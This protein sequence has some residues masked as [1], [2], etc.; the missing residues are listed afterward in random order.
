MIGAILTE[1]LQAEV[2]KQE[3]RDT[4]RATIAVF[5]CYG[6]TVVRFTT[7]LIHH[8]PPLPEPSTIV[9]QIS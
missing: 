9:Q 7:R 4:P 2:V 8:D 3:Y 5:D 1:L 6:L